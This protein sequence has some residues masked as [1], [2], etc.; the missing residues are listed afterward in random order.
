M[1][2]NK[3]YVYSCYEGTTNKNTQN[4]TDKKNTK[5]S[6]P[7]HPGLLSLHHTKADEAS[8]RC[9]V[10]L[11][12]KTLLFLFKKNKTSILACKSWPKP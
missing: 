12:D 1:T 4:T 9:R 3:P 11:S 8:L 6:T 7:K 5:P 10:E 2:F